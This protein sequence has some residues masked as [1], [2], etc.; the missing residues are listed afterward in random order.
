[1]SSQFLFEISLS[2][3]LFFL[4][5]LWHLDVT[6]IT[7]FNFFHIGNPVYELVLDI[8]NDFLAFNQ[9]IDEV[10]SHVEDRICRI[11]QDVFWVKKAFKVVERKLFYFL[12]FRNIQRVQLWVFVESQECSTNSIIL[13]VCTL[14][15]DLVLFT[16]NFVDYWNMLFCNRKVEMIHI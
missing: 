12:I 1:M 13:V 8:W 3:G 14:L 5:W 6:L 10:V 9:H 16:S 7:L 15:D 11:Y 4:E 2:L